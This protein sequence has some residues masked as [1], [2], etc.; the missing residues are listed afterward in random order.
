MTDGDI[1]VAITAMRH[2]GNERDYQG[3]ATI[4]IAIVTII[5]AVNSVVVVA[6]V[7]A[8]IV[9]IYCHRA[10]FMLLV[11]SLNLIERLLLYILICNSCTSNMTYEPRSDTVRI[12]V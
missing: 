11:I 8:V 9:N 1:G 2:H 3:S 12:Q 7:I 6:S 5:S 4:T 10:G